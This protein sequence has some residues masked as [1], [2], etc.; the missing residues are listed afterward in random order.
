VARTHAVDARCGAVMRGVSRTATAIVCHA[1][2]RGGSSARG[3]CQ[4][5]VPQYG[6]L[7]SRPTPTKVDYRY[8]YQVA[9]AAG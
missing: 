3:N 1:Q 4:S 6:R 7:S 9:R 8:L 5:R 2:S